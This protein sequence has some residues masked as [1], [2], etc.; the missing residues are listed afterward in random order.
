MPPNL[1]RHECLN[2]L[3]Y[4]ILGPMSPMEMKFGK[5]VATSLPLHL[6][7]IL[8]RNTYVVECKGILEGH[9]PTFFLTSSGLWTQ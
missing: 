7:T 4:K 2:K 6:L 3:T 8:P 1:F 9:F 5:V